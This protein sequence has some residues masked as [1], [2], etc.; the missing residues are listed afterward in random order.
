MHHEAAVHGALPQRVDGALVLRHRSVPLAPE[1]VPP[2]GTDAATGAPL[3]GTIQLWDART[4]T[5][6]TTAALATLDGHTDYVSALAA[7]PGGRL[8]SGSGDMTVRL[9]QLPP[10]PPR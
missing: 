7:L 9:W 2:G 4:A 10:P 1:R 3:G 6:T 5:G 8:A